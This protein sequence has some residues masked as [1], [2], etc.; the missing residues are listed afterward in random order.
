MKS[1]RPLRRLPST[2]PGSRLGWVLVLGAGLAC[3]SA[4]QV[5]LYDG[6]MSLQ[7]DPGGVVSSSRPPL[8]AQ[9]EPGPDWLAPLS[10]SLSWRILAGGRA[11]AIRPGRLVKDFIS[12]AAIAD[13][14]AEGGL[15]GRAVFRLV[16]GSLLLELEVLLPST[17]SFPASSIQVRAGA[18]P[19][20]GL[21]FTEGRAKRVWRWDRSSKS[22]RASG[23]PLPPPSADPAQW[24]EADAPL[25]DVVALAQLLR[26]VGRSV[27]PSG[28]TTFGPFGAT[29]LK[30]GGRVFWDAD[31]WIMPSL[32]L[33]SPER[34]KRV[35]EFRLR[36]A[37]AA[38]AWAA[39]IGP[40]RRMPTSRRQGL[41]LPALPPEQASRP[42]PSA[43]M[44]RYPW[45]ALP[46]GREG[47]VTES[48]FQE[49]I[50]ATVA[51]GLEKAAALGLVDRAKAS[52]VARDAAAWYLARSERSPDGLLSIKRVM[53][54]DESAIVDD[55]LYT[56]M[57]VQR[58][59]DRFAPGWR[60]RFPRD[61][62]TF[63]TWPGD[64]VSGYKQHAALLA[65][66]PLQ[67]PQAEREAGAMLDRFIGKAT[68]NGPAM[69]ISL[70][71]L[72]LARQGRA[73]DALERWRKS[74]LL[75]SA[76]AEFTER[77][78]GGEDVF[79][80]GAAG[81]L[82]AALYGFAG[83]RLDDKPLAGAAWSKQLKSGW[84]LSAKP[85]LPPGWR[86]IVIPR[87][88]IDGK[89]WRFRAEPGRA[90]AAPAG[91]G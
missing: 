41:N 48:I 1:S 30:Y 51:L 87:L 33:L 25:E 77:P 66:F 23:D 13:W 22:L 24:I 32:M 75:Y 17:A 7:V 86:S 45:E 26:I 39:A 58:L 35:A 59:F 15:Q 11:I 29:R 40:G 20:A 12:N 47:G 76:S 19:P 27:A 57:A 44:L 71:A 82:N 34:A 52:E 18:D 36:T 4:G 37:P 65:L 42:W 43:G 89:A 21:V 61:Q 53:S 90:E 9:P 73:T 79:A 81:C 88:M 49:H 78:V 68:A 5:L 6:G 56:N 54:P 67:N 60:L 3:P 85:A 16:D 63:L 70:E 72:L 84:W 62:R 83:L 91:R 80:T 38:R 55:D 64:P 10:A 28:P 46:D 74:W 2:T 8:M 50:T 69:S 31:V 14:T